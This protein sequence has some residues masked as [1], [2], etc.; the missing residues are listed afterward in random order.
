MA[1]GVIVVAISV[2]HADRRHQCDAQRAPAERG[3]HVPDASVVDRLSSDPSTAVRAMRED[4]GVDAVDRLSQCI[5]SRQVAGDDL[6]ALR[7]RSIWRSAGKKRTSCSPRSPRSIPM[8][9]IT[10]YL[11]VALPLAGMTLRVRFAS[12]TS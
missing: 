4:D 1:S 7:A 9:W 8:P 12:L 2:G 10:S 11:S 6:D 3:E 5:G